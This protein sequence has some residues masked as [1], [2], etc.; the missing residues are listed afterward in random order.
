M[1]PK[2]LSHGKKTPKTIDINWWSVVYGI[3]TKGLQPLRRL[4]LSKKAQEKDDEI[5]KKVYK[6]YTHYNDWRFQLHWNKLEWFCPKSKI[7]RKKL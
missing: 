7:K 6:Y 1:T 3:I 4:K 5:K 2:P